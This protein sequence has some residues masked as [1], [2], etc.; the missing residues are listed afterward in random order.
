[1]H[2][3][4]WRHGICSKQP[5][6]RSL[7]AVLQTVLSCVRI[8]H[9]QQKQGYKLSGIITELAASHDTCYIPWQI[10]LFFHGWQPNWQNIE[11][12]SNKMRESMKFAIKITETICQILFAERLIIHTARLHVPTFACIPF[13]LWLLQNN[14]LISNYLYGATQQIGPR[15]PHSWRF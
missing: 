8:L 1:M 10:A 14:L 7:L 4:S 12:M 15:P 9:W 3:V 5:R 11:Y 6:V 2:C 13:L